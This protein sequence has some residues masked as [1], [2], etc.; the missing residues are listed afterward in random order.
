MKQE[1][2]V[3]S[4]LKRALPVKLP[5]KVPLFLAEPTVIPPN[6]METLLSQNKLAIIDDILVDST[7]RH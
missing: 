4:T 6:H 2:K 1:D 5:L 7:S 3:K